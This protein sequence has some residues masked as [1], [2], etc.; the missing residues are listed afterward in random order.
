VAY[1]NSDRGALFKNDHKKRST[2]IRHG[3]SYRDASGG[4]G[5]G[6]EFDQTISNDNDVVLLVWEQIS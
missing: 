4:V 1:D 6:H 2:A 3:R 5:T